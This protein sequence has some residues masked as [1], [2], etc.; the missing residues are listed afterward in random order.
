[1]NYTSR[2]IAR[3]VG[4]T[5]RGAGGRVAVEVVYDH[6]LLPASGGL[7]AALKGENTD[8][9]RFVTAAADAQAA[10]IMLKEERLDEFEHLAERVDL[11]GVEEVAAAVWRLA[12]DH[13]LRFDIPVVA[14]T[15]SSGKTTTKNMLQAILERELGAG[16]ATRGNQ[17][18][19]LGVPLTLVRLDDGH[20]YLLA[21]LGTNAF[22]EI[23]SLSDLVKPMV[24]VLTG[25]MRAHLEGFGDV[26]GVL[27]EKSDLAQAVPAS[28]T[29]VLPSYDELL[30][31]ERGSLGAR[32]VTFGFAE[33]D[34]VRI[35][36]GRE[37]PEVSGAFAVGGQTFPVS[38]PTCGVF[39]LRNAAAAVAA[40]VTLGVAPG[41]AVGALGDYRPEMMRMEACR[42]GGATYIVDAYNANPESMKSA[43]DTLAAQPAQARIAVLG[44]MLELGV[45]SDALHEEVGRH[46]ASLGLDLLVFL[47]AEEGPYGAG[48]AVAGCAE[49]VRAADHDEAAKVLAERVGQGDVV[50]LKGSRGARLEDVMTSLMEA[51]N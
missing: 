20:A 36:D 2:Q 50:L 45:E 41:A 11:V 19:L 31:E 43:L 10:T 30:M 22:G 47:E 15:G 40:A 35:V 12:A 6:R 4:G 44:R 24:A 32:V 5:L 8:G 33:G 39:N 16:C 27:K 23:A 28:G 46:A 18:N 3:T 34:L 51:Q 49:V 38:L 42:V 48:A 9:H 17:N 29:V 26:R 25:V 37:G 1:M 13:R 21:E 7:F 14:I